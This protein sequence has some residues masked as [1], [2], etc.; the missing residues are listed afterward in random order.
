[1]KRAHLLILI[2]LSLIPLLNQA[3]TP[4]QTHPVE[5]V[6][7]AD[8]PLLPN[9][10]KLEVART[11]HQVA[12]EYNID[13]LLILAIMKVESSFRPNIASHRGAV[14]LMQMKTIAARE[15][16]KDLSLSTDISAAELA[17][18]ELN[19][20]LGVHYLTSL[21]K[22]FGGNIWKALSAYN[23]G[24]TAV[25]RNFTDQNITAKS[26]PGKVLRTYLAYT[27]LRKEPTSK[28]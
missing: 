18:H 26:Y 27:R 21:V 8:A 25:A 14:G 10:L 1:M 22:R 13:P 28:S 9:E 20:R 11:V 6:L 2:I 3:A 16:A 12:E 4:A 7:W 17:H 24:P 19:I 15:A 5:I 23:R